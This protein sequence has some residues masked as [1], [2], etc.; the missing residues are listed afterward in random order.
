[1][2]IDGQVMVEVP[3]FYYKRGTASGDPAWWI[4]D[5]P[6]TGFTIMPAFV[7]D[8][9]EVPAFQYGKY[10]ASESGGKLQSVAGVLPL[11]DTS[12]TDFLTKATARNVSGVTGFRLHHYDMWLAI[13]W[14]YLVE[15]ATMDSQTKTGQGRVSASSAANVDAADV[16]QA[17]YRGIVGLWGNVNQWMDG[18]RT[19]NGVIERRA[20]DAAGWV[21]TGES[22]PNGGG[23]TYPVTFRTSAPLEFIPDTYSAANDS[24]ATLPDYVRWRDSGEYYPF[25]GGYWSNGANAGLWCVNCGYLAS[26]AYSII[27]ARLSRIVS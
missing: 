6:L 8:S 19:L 23:A 11:V 27:G 10:Q 17:T 16:A 18:A 20:Y 5:Q 4:S 12:L 2:S 7:L 14:L 26:F 9:A 24:T 1:V 21:S 25:V 13:Q 3:R 22:V 15:N